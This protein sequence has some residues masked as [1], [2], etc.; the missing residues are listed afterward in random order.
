VKDGHTLIFARLI[1]DDRKEAAPGG[2]RARTELLENWSKL[3]T[4][5]LQPSN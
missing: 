1:Q 4:A 3:V 2:L 5:V